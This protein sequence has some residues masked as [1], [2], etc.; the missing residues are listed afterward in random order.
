MSK[1]GALGAL[2]AR[3]AET[4][5]RKISQLAEAPSVKQ[6]TPQQI[7]Q[8][9]NAEVIMRRRH[10]ADILGPDRRMVNVHEN[11]K[12]AAAAGAD[13]SIAV[14]SR[15]EPEMFGGT[16]VNYGYLTS[17]PFSTTKIPLEEFYPRNSNSTF[18]RP[19]DV[20]PQYG[21]YGFRV[22]PQGRSKTTFTLDDSLDRGRGVYAT[23]ESIANPISPYHHIAPDDSRLYQLAKEYHDRIDQLHKDAVAAGD[24]W[25]QQQGQLA[26]RMKAEGYGGT[27]SDF[28][29]MRAGVRPGNQFLRLQPRPVDAPDAIP[30]MNSERNQLDHHAED[31]LSRLLNRDD[32]TGMMGYVEAQMLGGAELGDFDRLYDFNYEPSSAL[33][34][35][36]RKLG[37]EYVPMPE[38]NLYNLVQRHKPQNMG[39]LTD[40]LGSKGFA[41]YKFYRPSNT[42]ADFRRARPVP[43]F[44]QG[45][46]AGGPV[47]AMTIV[48]RAFRTK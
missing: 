22:G 30:L 48:D 3:L 32:R 40:L 8:I 29:E 44:K 34:K 45:F 11:R 28:L 10:T 19:Y 33:E 42:G 43:K 7:E 41:E 13:R 26:E 16:D 38:D 20:L 12:T 24:W 6:L 31:G 21:Q 46:A 14:R 37:L 47:G 35:K 18:L 4:S 17:D 15:H 1:L 23:S 9:A 39:E 36:I 25:A 2:M 5:G 27:F